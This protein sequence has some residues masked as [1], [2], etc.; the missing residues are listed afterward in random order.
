MLAPAVAVLPLSPRHSHRDQHSGLS[1]ASLT[2]TS[3]EALDVINGKCSHLGSSPR[4]VTATLWPPLPGDLLS[5][6]VGSEYQ[7]PVDPGKIR[8]KRALWGV[9]GKEAKE[10]CE[11]LPSNTKPVATLIASWMPPPAKQ[12]PLYGPGVN[13]GVQSLP[14]VGINA[15]TATSASLNFPKRSAWAQTPLPQPPVICE[16]RHSRSRHG[17]GEVVPALWRMGRLL[18]GFPAWSRGP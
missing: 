17:L 13:S 12:I 2:K 8:P 15:H 4:G 3:L 5:G 6:W 18:A 16:A 7:G 14:A 1:P 10:A 11:V 9:L